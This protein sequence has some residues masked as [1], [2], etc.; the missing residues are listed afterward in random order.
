[1]GLIK[2]TINK[3]KHPTGWELILPKANGLNM[4]FSNDC[5]LS[6]GQWAL[7]PIDFHCKSIVLRDH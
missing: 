7:H 4:L 6:W 2:P 3:S 5:V 1:M